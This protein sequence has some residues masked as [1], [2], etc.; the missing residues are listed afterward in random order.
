MGTT[1]TTVVPPLNESAVVPTQEIKIHLSKGGR[2]W[3]KYFWDL[4]RPDA[5]GDAR[6]ALLDA[7]LGNKTIVVPAGAP[8]DMKVKISFGG[9]VGSNSYTFA[10]AGT[11][12]DRTPKTHYY[13]SS[14]SSPLT[15]TIADLK[16][17][18]NLVVVRYNTKKDNERST[19]HAFPII[20]SRRRLAET[21]KPDS[22]RARRLGWKPSHDMDWSPDYRQRRR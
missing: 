7:P 19:A 1:A 21:P 11:A 20:L 2:S 3:N 16:K 9:T 6:C 4:R 10:I 17:M 5:N 12:A 18:G 15:I 14:K 13:D 22:I 8:D